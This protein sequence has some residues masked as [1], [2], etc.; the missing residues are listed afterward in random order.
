MP[1]CPYAAAAITLAMAIVST[2]PAGE[3]KLGTPIGDHMVV[4][5]GRPLRVWGQADP[6]ADVDVRLGPRRASAT[7]GPDGRWEAALD[8]LPAGGPHVLSVG[9]GGG[10]AEVRDVL[11]GDVWLCSGQSNMQMTL[12]ESDRGPAAAAAAVKLS[13]L[14][15]ASVGRRASAVPETGAEIHWRTAS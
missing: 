3:V 7:A 11:V 4:Q 10:S 9:A 5:R 13:R 14:R 6:G 12:K 2:A 8:A 1:D 15:L